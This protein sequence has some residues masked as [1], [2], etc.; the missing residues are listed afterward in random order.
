MP[1]PCARTR[2]PRPPGLAAR[3][4]AAGR[5]SPRP[6]KMGWMDGVA[7]YRAGF[8]LGP[9]VRAAHPTVRTT[10][11]AAV[12]GG[13]VESTGASRR[14]TAPGRTGRTPSKVRKPWQTGSTAGLDKS[15][16]QL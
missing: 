16:E 10:D 9:Y 7:G 13:D 6:Q 5:R 12:G 3:P 8:Y 15:A 4:R 1:K 14:A 2:S 11:A